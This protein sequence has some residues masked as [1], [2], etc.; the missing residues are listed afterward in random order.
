MQNGMFLF[1]KRRWEQD[2][3][4]L[5]R[6][7]GYFKDKT[8]PLQLFIFPEGTNMENSALERSHKYAEKNNLV[9]YDYV[10][11][12]R[13]TGFNYIVEQLRKTSNEGSEGGLLDCIHDVTV[14][15]QEDR[16]YAEKDLVLGNFPKEIH[17]HIQKY[18]MADIPTESEDVGRWCV[19]RW[20]EKEERLKNFHTGSKSFVEGDEKGK[21]A[22]DCS[23]YKTL[24]LVFWTLFM[25]ASFYAVYVFPLAFW[26]MIIMSVFYILISAFGNGTDELQLNIHEI[27]TSLNRGMHM[28][29][30]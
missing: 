1:L 2:K 23:L 4:Y 30:D 7:L 28:K 5:T 21:L 6:V 24:A 26:Y 27:R 8:Y 25:W 20:A 22:A 12:P 14:A 11:H 9:K 16:C 18:D 15:Y 29:D 19:Q 13:V 10:L 17:L 3:G